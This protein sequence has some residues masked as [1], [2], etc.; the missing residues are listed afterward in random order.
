[1]AMRARE[2]TLTQHTTDYRAQQLIDIL[3]EAQSEPRDFE[4]TSRGVTEV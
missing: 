2:R 3:T 1:M 4:R